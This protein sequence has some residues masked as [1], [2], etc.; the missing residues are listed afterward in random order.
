LSCKRDYKSKYL[1]GNEYNHTYIGGHIHFLALLQQRVD[2]PRVA[3]GGGGVDTPGSIL[4]G[5]VEVD[6]LLEEHR[7]ALSMTVE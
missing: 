6:A 5:H 4:I 3:I 1:V 2:D 7:G